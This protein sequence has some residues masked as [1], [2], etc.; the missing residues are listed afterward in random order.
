VV[1]VLCC[2]ASIWNLCIIAAVKQYGRGRR[3]GGNQKTGNWKLEE[4]DGKEEG[5]RKEGE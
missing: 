5:R 4:K 1:D 2:T 3:M